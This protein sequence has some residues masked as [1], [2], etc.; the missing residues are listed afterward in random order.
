M[1]LTPTSS[2]TVGPFFSIGLAQLCQERQTQ[3]APN[4]ITLAGTLR[5]G[6]AQP[7]P[8]AVL[9]FWTGKH[10]VRV[11]SAEDGSFSAVLSLP[12]AAVNSAFS[13]V[14]I[15]MRGL[16]R[17]VRTRVYFEEPEAIKNIPE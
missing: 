3:A 14:L 13:D 8:D 1:K 9:E 17:P 11:A 6:D 16:L 7:I 4:A 2:Q 10:F 12:S 15:L 5:D